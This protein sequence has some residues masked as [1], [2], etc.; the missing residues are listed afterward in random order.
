M[1]LQQEEVPSSGTRQVAK[2]TPFVDSAVNNEMLHGQA[3][4]PLSVPDIPSPESAEVDS[5]PRDAIVSSFGEPE[6]QKELPPTMLRLRNFAVDPSSNVNSSSSSSAA[7][8]TSPSASPPVFVRAPAS[9]W[10]LAQ[11]QP[12]PTQPSASGGRVTSFPEA[13]SKFLRISFVLTATDRHQVSDLL[14]NYST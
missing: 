4:D 1:N 3:D 5:S 7:A 8:S 10:H 12:E 6:R 13:A 14:M 2:V 9:S 11:G